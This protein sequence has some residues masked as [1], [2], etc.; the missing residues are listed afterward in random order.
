MSNKK[1]PAMVRLAGVNYHATVYKVL[2]RDDDG[3]PR[4][5]E[6]L[7]DHETTNVEDGMEFWVSYTSERVLNKVRN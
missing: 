5:F 1:K 4:T 3:S 2:T 6:I 7:R